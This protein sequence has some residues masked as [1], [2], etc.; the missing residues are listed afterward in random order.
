MNKKLLGICGLGLVFSL[1]ACGDDVNFNDPAAVQAFL[2]KSDPQGVRKALEK[3]RIALNPANFIN[4]A[5][6]N[7]TLMMNVFL[8]ASYEIDAADD[9]GNN[10]VA[11]AVNK[12]Q[13]NVLNYLFDHGAKANVHNSTG[14]TVLENAVTMGNADVV[15]LL[16]D[17]L[18]KE[19]VDPSLFSTGVLIAA[20]NG[21]V[22]MLQVL[23]DNGAPLEYRSAD[24]DLPIHWT[25]KNGNYD[26]MM[27]LIGKK[28]DVNAPC[29]QG[30]TALDWATELSYTRLKSALKKAGGKNTPQY[31]DSKRK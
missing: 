5:V 13:I 20:K 10:A 28:V 29:H 3:N 6:K 24:G 14:E 18:K 12:G 1:A 26:A 7:D 9:K 8:K 23:A 27:F 30:Y 11:I 2:A 19:G 15:K 22:D 4:Y 21:N 31:K 16:V 25:V 17:Q